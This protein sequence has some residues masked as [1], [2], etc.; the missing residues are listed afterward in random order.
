M[1]IIKKSQRNAEKRQNE[2][3]INR[4]KYFLIFWVNIEKVQNGF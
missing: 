4:I 3:K 2:F 1:K